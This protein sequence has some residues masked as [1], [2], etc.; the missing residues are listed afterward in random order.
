VFWTRNYTI[1]QRKNETRMFCIFVG[2]IVVDPI[3][4]PNNIIPAGWHPKRYEDFMVDQGFM[5]IY[6]RT[7]PALLSFVKFNGKIEEY[8]KFY[9]ENQERILNK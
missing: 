7:T 2:K 9:K 4:Y 8:E 5:P 6:G 1:R 3:I